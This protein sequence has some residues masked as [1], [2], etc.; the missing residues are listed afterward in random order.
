MTRVDVCEPWYHDKVYQ[1]YLNHGWHP[2]ELGYI[3]ED[4]YVYETLSSRDTIGITLEE[5]MQLP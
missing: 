3:G 1:S 4:L 2:Y 5:R